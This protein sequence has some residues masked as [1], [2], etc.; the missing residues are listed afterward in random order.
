VTPTFDNTTDPDDFLFTFRRRDEAATDP[1]TSIVVEYGSD[2]AGWTQ[3]QDGVDG[4]S[5]DDTTD[6]GG[7]LHQVTVGIPR[8]LDGGTSKLFARLKVTVTP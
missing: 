8:A 3:A 1:N 4:V 2:L 6:L 5:I 7:G